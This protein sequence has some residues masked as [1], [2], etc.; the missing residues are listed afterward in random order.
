MAGNFLIGRDPVLALICRLCLLISVPFCLFLLIAPMP[1]IGFLWDIANASGFLGTSLLLLLFFY[2][3]RPLTRPY[4]DGKFFMVL[5]RDIGFVAAMLVGLH[6]LLLLIIQPLTVEYLEP[7]ATWPMLS[8][9][10]AGI[11]MILLI[12][13]SLTKLRQ[14]IWRKH[15]QFKRWHYVASV[16]ILLAVMLHVLGTGFYTHG[17]WKLVLCVCLVAV[18]VLKP[19]RSGPMLPKGEGPR[20]RGTAKRASWLSL[21]FLLGL[22]TLALGF[23]ILANG[24]LPL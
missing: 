21:G 11:L 2:S 3:G 16:L 12:P 19:L 7:S 18:A 8:G 4:Y 20:Q 9:T 15:V 13:L 23:S 5:H 10:I 1:G 24:D 6:V 17:V 14:K 22:I